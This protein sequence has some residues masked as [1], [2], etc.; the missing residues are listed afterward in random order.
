MGFAE[1]L[2]ISFVPNG[3]AYSDAVAF[4]ILIVVL[5]FKPAGIMGRNV[6]EKV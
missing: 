3:S 5:L 6:A 4:T 2:V 1:V